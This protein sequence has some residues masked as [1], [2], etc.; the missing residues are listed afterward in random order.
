MIVIGVDPGMNTGVAIYANG[1]LVE[2]RTVLPWALVGVFD[3]Q[4][5]GLVVF[6]DSRLE[7][8]VWTPQHL[9]LQVKMK[10]GRNV[11]QVDA[12]CS[13]IQAEC[14]KRNIDCIGISPKDKGSKTN[15][16]DFQQITSWRGLSNEHTRDAAMVS[17]NFRNQKGAKS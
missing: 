2:L 14:A 13:L 1:K 17:W 8:H 3:E 16:P 7:S 12:W 9:P 5:P 4:Q 6:E 10:Y 15:A 11:G